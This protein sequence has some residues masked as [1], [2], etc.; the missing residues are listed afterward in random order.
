MATAP[1]AE[2]DPDRCWP[3]QVD[4]CSSDAAGDDGRRNVGQEPDGVTR[5]CEHHADGRAHVACCRTVPPS[6]R[7]Q[8]TTMWKPDS[9]SRYDC[10]TPGPRMQTGGEGTPERKE[11]KTDTSQCHTSNNGKRLS[12][13]SHFAYG[14]RGKEETYRIGN[15]C[16]P[17]LEVNPQGYDDLG[18]Q[19]P[20]FAYDIDTKGLHKSRTAD[21]DTQ[22]TWG[23]AQEAC[24]N[25]EGDGWRLC[26]EAEL[27]LG[28]CCADSSGMTTCGIAH[29]DV[30]TSEMCDS[31]L[32]CSVVEEFEHS[33]GT[34]EYERG[35]KLSQ[36]LQG[37]QCEKE[38]REGLCNWKGREY[39]KRRK[40]GQAVCV[41][42]DKIRLS[43]GGGGKLGY[44]VYVTSSVYESDLESKAKAAYPIQNGWAVLV[45]L[46]SDQADQYAAACD[47]SLQLA[48]C[49]EEERNVPV[50][51]NLAG[52]SSPD[53]ETGVASTSADPKRRDFATVTPVETFV[54]V[55]DTGIRST[56]RAFGGRVLPGKAVWEDGAKT[57]DDCKGCP[58]GVTCGNCGH[59]TH[60][61][62]TV[63]GYMLD[64]QEK[65]IGVNPNAF[66]VPVNIFDKTSQFATRKTFLEALAWV[67]TDAAAKRKE[68]PDRRFVASLSLCAGHINDGAG[69]E[70]GWAAD[71]LLELRAKDV[72]VCVAACNDG[73]AS[74]TTNFGT[75]ALPNVLVV[76]SHSEAL[77]TSAFSG[78]GTAIGVHARGEDVWSAGYDGD[79]QVLKKTGTSMATPYVAGLATLVWESNK[80]LNA[81]EVV[82]HIKQHCTRPQV[83]NNWR[84]HYSTKLRN[85]TPSNTTH[86]LV[87]RSVDG[88][89]AYSYVACRGACNQPALAEHYGVDPSQVRARA[90]RRLS[91]P[92]NHWNHWNLTWAVI[93]G[94]VDDPPL[95]LAAVDWENVDN[96][97]GAERQLGN[98]VAAPPRAR[99]GEEELPLHLVV[100]AASGGVVVLFLFFVCWCG[101]ARGAPKRRALSVH[102]G[103]CGN[104]DT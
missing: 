68:N 101:R 23:Y 71:V 66:V 70:A 47:P 8:C 40:S 76:A 59:G 84:D 39:D 81:S 82:D 73:Y 50:P 74:A 52:G 33:F 36:H 9:T 65:Q 4:V 28:A 38:D 75:Y 41:P 67:A 17:V 85:C 91:V 83:F 87:D 20:A 30:W 19:W 3:L 43:T 96:P 86:A 42:K 63:A 14:F 22:A 10:I 90:G 69:W 31:G 93:D 45:D 15:R 56:H 29:T 6:Q 27:D 79:W 88:C 32:T 44:W 94:R 57:E 99:G 12:P 54:Y 58:D 13:P 55:V 64:H 103:S 60:C 24:A 2:T 25:V 61:A 46:T 11:W 53:V 77:K 48:N 97:G 104:G 51:S 62:G 100:V 7:V 26:T 21:N 72:V 98:H 78:W 34:I 18:R 37:F 95:P 35:G 1:C 49:V 89:L 80:D 5:S 102:R 16:S 92:E